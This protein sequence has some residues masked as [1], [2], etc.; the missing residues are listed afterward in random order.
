MP[1]HARLRR[2]QRVLTREQSGSPLTNKENN[3]PLT[4]MKLLA[5]MRRTGLAKSFIEVNFGKIE[6]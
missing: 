6:F 4:A 1:G 5:R 2:C 3:A